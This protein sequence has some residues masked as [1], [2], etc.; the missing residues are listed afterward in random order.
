MGWIVLIILVIYLGR[1]VEAK[2]KPR[3]QYDHANG[4][5]FLY[6]GKEPNRKF[7]QLSV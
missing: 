5:L 2:Y 4:K 3:P 7:I 1:L 6:Y